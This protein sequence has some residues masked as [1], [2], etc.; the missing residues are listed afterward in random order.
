MA[1][2]LGPFLRAGFEADVTFHEKRGLPGG[3]ET[4]AALHH[5][6]TGLLW[7]RLTVPLVPDTE[8]GEVAAA[9]T[10]RIV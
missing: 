8:P 7:D 10:R 9:L 2:C 4:V 1:D 5:A 3:R 6:I